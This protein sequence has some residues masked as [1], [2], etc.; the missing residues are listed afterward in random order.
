M[1]APVE[2]KFYYL[3]LFPFLYEPETQAKLLPDKES[4][5]SETYQ[6]SADD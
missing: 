4:S 1:M 3:P 6:S 2:K 5:K